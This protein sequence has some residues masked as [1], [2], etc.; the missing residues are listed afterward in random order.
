MK[1]VASSMM[2]GGRSG[3]NPMDFG[4]Q[5]EPNKSKMKGVA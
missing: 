3:S 4:R 1:G 2:G 5:T